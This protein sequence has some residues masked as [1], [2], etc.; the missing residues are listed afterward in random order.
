[1]AEPIDVRIDSMRLGAALGGAALFVLVS[2][3]CLHFAEGRGE[4]LFAGWLGVVTFAGM[5]LLGVWRLARGERLRILDDRLQVVTK[6]GRV[7]G[8]IP[9]EAIETV[10]LIEVQ[11]RPCCGL[12]LRRGAEVRWGSAIFRAVNSVAGFLPNAYWLPGGLVEPQQVLT[13]WIVERLELWRATRSG[14]SGSR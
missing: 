10:E 9:F 2:V 3:A 13:D 4:L 14:E 1:L 7:V 6:G 11:G 12:R 5:G 8:E